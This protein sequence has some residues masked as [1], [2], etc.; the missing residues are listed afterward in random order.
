MY[1]VAT[2]TLESR[3]IAKVYGVINMY[4]DDHNPENLDHLEQG[5]ARLENDAAQ[6]ILRIHT[7]IESGRR[8][9]SMKR[10]EL[11][12][13]RKFVYLLHYRRTSL[14]SSYFDEN[15]PDNRPLKDYMRVFRRKHNLHNKDDL[16]LSGLKYILDTPHHKIVGTGEAIQEMYGGPTAM[17]SMLMTRVDPDIENYPAVD[18]TAMANAN[19]LGI[20]EAPEGEE[21][22]VGSN[23][24]GLWEGVW[25]AFLECIESL[26]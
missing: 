24:F 15:D 22:I 2:Q 3:P 13:I 7:A 1:D 12:S 4:R 17:L 21:F 18:Y 20:W 25:M 16:W 14:L 5:L 19:F 8:K 6:T 9:I 23:S 11:E 26:S 10:K